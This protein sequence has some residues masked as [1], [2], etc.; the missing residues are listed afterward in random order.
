MPTTDL[1]TTSASRGP[2][3][4]GLPTEDGPP[5]AVAVAAWHLALSN[6]IGVDVPHDLLALWLFPGRGGVVLLAPLELGSDRVELA[7]PERHLSQHQLF[8]L[9]ERIRGAG[10]RS[11]LAVPIRTSERDLGLV[12]FAHLEPARFGAPEA[13]R[14]TVMMR[15]VVPTFVALAAAPPL[16]PAGGPAAHLTAANAPEAVARA[17]AEAETGADL[18]R[19]VSGMLQVLVPHD[20]L[21]VVVPGLGG[22]WALLSGPPEGQRWGEST[23]TVSQ[24]VLGFI[25]RADE[26]GAISI[27]DLRAI[28]LAWPTYRES[29]ALGRI[30]ALLGARL[31]VAGSDDAWLL[32]G[33]AAPDLYRASD[34]DVLASIAP[35]LAL[36]VQGLR[37]GLAAEVSRSQLAQTQTSQSRAARIA[38]ALAGTAHWGDAV[39]YFVKDVRES[40][41][42][43][44]ARFVLRFGE[45]RFV[46]V[47]AGDLRPL[48]ALPSS[49]IDG[50]GL[51]G[52]F[53]GSAP[54][55]VAGEAGTELLV[56]LRVAGRV[57]GALELSGAEPGAA[58]HPVTAAQLF[59][60]LIAPHLELVRRAAVDAASRESR[61][62][63]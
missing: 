47:E 54:F 35:V 20:R 59:A 36:R 38:G 31:R 16:A 23:V 50:S 42:Y 34:R 14:L 57:V 39:V 60:D 1:P 17:A 43:D 61:V 51:E 25:A 21:E 11:V 32:L 33:G 13:I 58:G 10:Y 22:A 30:H 12:V 6:L 49:E 18:L 29:R 44:D 40:L 28:G 15:Q 45:G 2:I 27:G 63:R 24:A 3:V 4:P 52:L 26:D 9:E 46:T 41:G 5:D 7:A 8:E 48:A 55:L 62:A 56:P 19:Q 37:A 53:A